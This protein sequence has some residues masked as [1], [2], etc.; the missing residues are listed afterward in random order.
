VVPS[1]PPITVVEP[2]VAAVIDGLDV[3]TLDTDAASA[4]LDLLI[5]HPLLVLPGQQLEP[6]ELATFAALFGT[7]QAF[8]KNVAHPECGQVV[9]LTNQSKRGQAAAPYWHV[10]GLLLEDPP[11]FTTF[12]AREV[13]P[14]GGDT[15][16]ADA[17]GAWD[18]LA[19]A[20]R[21]ALDGRQAVLETGV[22]HPLVR[23][24]PLT[25]APAICLNA[26]RTM[27]IVGATRES[28]ARLM[29]E[30]SDHVA[31]AERVYRHH[32]RP[33]DLLLWDNFALAHSATEPVDPSHARVMLRCDIHL[34][35]GLPNP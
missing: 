24:H 14:E 10:D 31:E 4:L 12:Y 26:G 17:R 22:R 11:L 16:F 5:E 13:P 7:P 3:R 35:D 30:L 19:P 34:P 8:P 23:L 9:E 18:A 1:K 33:G 15:L 28:A 29:R 32:Y 6:G 2:G 20:E 25:G 21:D 27:G